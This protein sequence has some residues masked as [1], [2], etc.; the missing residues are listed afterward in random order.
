MSI[1]DLDLLNQ[2]SNPIEFLH[3]I[4]GG[5]FGD[6]Y[7][8]KVT[9]K[10]VLQDCRKNEYVAVKIPK[11]PNDTR[12]ASLI[13]RESL[14]VV[15]L[16]SQEGKGQEN[17]V[18]YYTS[19]FL[20]YSETRIV[21]IL[22]EY[23]KDGDLRH[24][25]GGIQE[26]KRLP[27]SFALEIINGILKGL[28]YIHSRNMLHLD[29]KPENILLEGRIPKIADLGTSKFKDRTVGSIVLGTVYY[30]SPEK[31]RGKLELSEKEDLWAVSVIL[32]EM[33]GGIF[34][35][36]AG[37][38][39]QQSGAIKNNIIDCQPPPLQELA[40]DLPAELV[41][42]VNHSLRMDPEERYKDAHNMLIAFSS[43][44]KK[45]KNK[46]NLSI[47]ALKR[48]ITSSQKYDQKTVDCI[49]RCVHEYPTEPEVVRIA[50]NYFHKFRMIDRA[51]EVCDRVVDL[52]LNPVTQY[53]C[54]L[55]YKESGQL[56]A[57]K[58]CFDRTRTSR[59]KTEYQKRANSV[60][61][62]LGDQ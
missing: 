61:T 35:F 37:L 20:D 56:N 4:G 17:V 48:Q 2:E 21:V 41:T 28:V 32:Y 23:V 43:Y 10:H 18:Q 47:Q 62:S 16:T 1:L 57:A 52:T 49:F 24:Y 36:G 40:A 6:T 46:L 13:L 14:K 50:V 55:A 19:I 44:Q 7:R 22:M 15:N 3:F 8:A 58:I 27:T 60:L 59:L 29:I 38:D 31:C 26:P 34:P 39:S 33:L 42:L 30:D 54:G 11:N 53:Y 12:W 51:L 45:Y 5:T 9:D 25:L